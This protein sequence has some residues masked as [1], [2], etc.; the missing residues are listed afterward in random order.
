MPTPVLI[1]YTGNVPEQ[2]FHCRSK[3]TCLAEYTATYKVGVLGKMAKII[4]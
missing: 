4:E 2:L 1:L 3:G